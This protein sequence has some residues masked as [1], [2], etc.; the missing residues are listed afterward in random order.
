MTMRILG[1]PGALRAGSTN[2]ML[3]RVALDAFA[4]HVPDVQAEVADLRLPLYDGDL[5]D[6]EGLPEGVVRLCAQVREADGIVISTPEYNKNPP[7]VLKNAL[8][9]ISR[10]KPQPMI[11]KPVAVMSSAAGR[12]GG[13]LSQAVLRG[14]L[15]PFAPRLLTAP[16][17]ALADARSQFDAEGRLLNQRAAEG[18]GRLMEALAAEIRR[19]RAASA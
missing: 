8:D 2:R 17:V 13:A 7:G 16:E 14:M 15:V 11:G 10:D 19:G 5:E 6:A 18:A 12:A 9:W 1:I 4:A 3:L